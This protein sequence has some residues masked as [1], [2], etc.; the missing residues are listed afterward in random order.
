MPQCP[1][2]SRQLQKRDLESRLISEP[3]A[4]PVYGAQALLPLTS[5]AGH[6]G[7]VRRNCSEHEKT[8]PY[9]EVLSTSL[10]SPKAQKGLKAGFFM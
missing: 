8:K 5:D 6:K 3:A 7:C 1:G 9:F 2:L 10:P 4:A